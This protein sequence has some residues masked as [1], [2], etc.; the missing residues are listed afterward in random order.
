MRSHRMWVSGRKFIVALYGS[1]S[2]SDLEDRVA[3]ALEAE[4][5]WS[6]DS[7]V[8]AVRVLVLFRG[9]HCPPSPET[10]VLPE[11]SR[12][13]TEWW[14]EQWLDESGRPESRLVAMFRWW[15]RAVVTVAL[16]EPHAAT[17]LAGLVARVARGTGSDGF[18]LGVDTFPGMHGTALELGHW[19]GLCSLASS[20]EEDTQLRVL[21]RGVHGD[22]SEITELV[23]DR[24]CLP[25]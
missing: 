21:R 4:R 22:S 5:F 12:V 24:Y 3:K 6:S 1:G 20:H 13:C 17:E 23:Y 15:T 16:A 7:R 10:G 18:I 2:L 25:S 14:N 8:G 19:S 11:G 9:D